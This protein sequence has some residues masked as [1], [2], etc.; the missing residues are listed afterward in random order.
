LSNIPADPRLDNLYAEKLGY[1]VSPLLREIRRE[2]RVEL[3]LEGLRRE[4]LARWKAGRLMEV[5]FR[6]MKFTPEKQELYNGK[7]T[8]KPI[9]AMQAVLNVDVFVD[10]EGFIIGYPKSPRV[11]NGTLIWSDQYY[12]WPIPLQELELNKNLT[13]SPQWQDVS[14]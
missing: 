9:I 3:A 7:Q 5:P 6:G 8:A 2:R 11:T 14:R 1:A 10:S 12:Y 13:Q 4:D